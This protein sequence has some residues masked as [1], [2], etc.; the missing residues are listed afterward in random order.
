MTVSTHILQTSKPTIL[1]HFMI[2]FLCINYTTSNTIIQM[3]LCQL[4]TRKKV[5]YIHYNDDY[6]S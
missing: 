4:R 5:I 2:Y 3:L 1:A 6:D